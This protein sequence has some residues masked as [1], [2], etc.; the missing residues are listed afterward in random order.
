MKKRLYKLLKKI[1][2]SFSVFTLSGKV[3]DCSWKDFLYR[4]FD[5]FILRPMENFFYWL[6]TSVQYSI[7]LWHNCHD[8]DFGS[9]IRLIRFK[10]QRKYEWFSS[11]KPNI[12]EAKQVAA[13]IK[14]V[15]DAIDYYLEQD[16]TPEEDKAHE[17]KWGEIEMDLSEKVYYDNGEVM[18][19]R[20]RWVSDKIKTKEDEEREREDMGVIVKLRQ[21]RE[22]EAWSAI[23]DKMKRSNGWWD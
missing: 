3:D 20:L 1:D 5:Y 7:F 2:Y 23:W 15:I 10:L 13:E 17:E 18:G 19:S 16:F 8:W 4:I 14:E 12:S 6:K 22:L 11:D 21:E 9:M